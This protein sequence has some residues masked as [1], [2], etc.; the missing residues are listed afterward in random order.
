MSWRGAAVLFAALVLSG[1]ETARSGLDY[2][3][4]MQR[5]GP[6]KPG[7]SRIVI[8]REKGFGGIVDGGWQVQ[9]DGQQMSGLKTGTYVYA[10]RGTGQH[11]LGAT[12]AGF[13]GVTRLDIATVS[14]RTYFYVARPSNRKTAFAAN[15]STGVLGYVLTA[16][17]TTAYENPGPL[18]FFPLDD[19]AAKVTI[20]ELRP[21]E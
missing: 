14:G 12:E 21:A 6:P 5:I 10:D 15:A 2:S 8:L 18:D 13:P 17:L 1:C 4:M 19:T 9:V 11:Q 7:Q 20:A 16:A 3:G